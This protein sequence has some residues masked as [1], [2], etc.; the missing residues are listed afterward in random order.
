VIGLNSQ[1]DK[2]A[3]P[4]AGAYE[5][6]LRKPGVKNGTRRGR[7]V[8]TNPDKYDGKLWVDTPKGRVSNIIYRSKIELRL[9][10]YLDTHP[11]VLK[12]S[13]EA[14]VIPYIS[15]LDGRVHRY[16]VDVRATIKK[17]DGSVKT[18]LI[19]VKWSTACVPPKLPQS[20][21]KTRRYLNELKNWEIN[22]AKWIEAKKVCEKQGWEWLILTE[23][24]LTF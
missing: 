19:E 16:F 7:Y 21:R 2:Q 10:K 1:V 24:Q 11:S 22:Q 17:K 5:V 12:W 20:K 4:S 9:I 3:T 18:Y 23:K 15:P 8:P 14:V 6:P 13:S